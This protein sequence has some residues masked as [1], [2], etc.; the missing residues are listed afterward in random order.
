MFWAAAL[1][2]EAG[3]ENLQVDESLV[4]RAGSHTVDHRKSLS[5]SHREA[6]RYSSPLHVCLR[7]MQVEEEYHPPV[8]HV[9]LFILAG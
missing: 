3:E 6:L 8:H 4:Y 7:E 1:Q 5:D 9:Y 2:T